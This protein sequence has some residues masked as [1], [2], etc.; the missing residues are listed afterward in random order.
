MKDGSVIYEKDLS[1]V[2]DPAKLKK[3]KKN[4]A[5]GAEWGVSPKVR[6][7]QDSIFMRAHYSIPEAIDEGFCTKKKVKAMIDELHTKMMSLGVQHTDAKMDNL[8]VNSVSGRVQYIDIGDMAKIGHEERFVYTR[9][10]TQN[11]IGDDT[12]LRKR[13]GDHIVRA[14]TDKTGL[15]G[16]KK[17][18]D[19]L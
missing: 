8:V 4:Y 13:Q 6:V 11:N 5:S 14:Q 9:G 12:T 18:I 2:D 7:Y 10:G 3:I 16:V 15:D 19:K 1:Q 17:A